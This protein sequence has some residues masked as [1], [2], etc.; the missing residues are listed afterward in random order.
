MKRSK[1][2]SFLALL[3]GGLGGQQLP[4]ASTQYGAFAFPDSSGTRLIATSELSQPA[5]LHTAICGGGR[6]ISV[7]F[8]GRQDERQGHNGRQT[9]A[10]FDRLAGSLFAITKGKIESD[11]TCFLAAGSLL[12]GARVLP[13]ARQS[14]P[15]RC[16][17]A[18][19]NTIAAERRRG[20]VNCWQIAGPTAGKR[21]ALVEFGRQEQNA[22]A[23]MVL[24]DGGRAIFQNYPGEVR[25]EGEDLWRVGDGG[26]FSPAGFEI[27]FLLQ[28]GRFYAVGIDWRGEEGNSLGVFVSN[29]ED[30]FTR[31]IEDYWYRAPL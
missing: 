10:N 2:W 6:R 18:V 31:V 3:A 29:G 27:V 4:P 9:P 14:Q 5:G 21:L 20:V 1:A 8:I 30:Y 11:A 7:K 15:G 23:S 12:S 17:P 25:R 24:I 16:D 13:I 26:V 22:L 28:R 19:S